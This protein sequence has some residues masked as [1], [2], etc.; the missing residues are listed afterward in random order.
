MKKIILSIL[1]ITLLVTLSIVL[2]DD[3]DF[4]VAE[5]FSEVNGDGFWG[6]YGPAYTLKDGALVFDSSI[7]NAWVTL[8]FKDDFLEPDAYRYVKITMKTDDPTDGAKIVMTFGN[9]KKPISEWGIVLKTEYTT[10][11]ID[12][13]KQG[14]TKWGD[15]FK[16]EP[17]FALNKGSA[18]KAKLYVKSI[19]LTNSEK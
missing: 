5:S 12:L 18:V 6:P 15:G 14:L 2:A 8:N 13:F 4:I 1:L 10:Y 19:I 17:D 11:V 16:A 9:I 7:D 3:E